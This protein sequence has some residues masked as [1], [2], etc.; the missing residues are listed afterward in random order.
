MALLPGGIHMGRKDKA[1]PIGQNTVSDLGAK[2]RFARQ[3]AGI[4]LTQMAH[5]VG[6]SKSYI[7]SVENGTVRP[8]PRLMKTYEEKLKFKVSEVVLGNNDQ[9]QPQFHLVPS[10]ETAEGKTSSL[11]I[12]AKKKPEKQ[13]V[14][15]RSN[16]LPG[17]RRR[18]ED[19]GEAPDIRNFHG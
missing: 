7:S 1:I 10:G 15:R 16:N 12:G 19:W 6:C 3:N 8:S 18:I 4:S 11:V 9:Q 14:S 13:P 2:L 17:R 5:E